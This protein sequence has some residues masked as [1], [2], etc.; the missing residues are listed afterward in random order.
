MRILAPTISC[1]RL[2]RIYPEMLSAG[3]KEAMQVHP[4]RCTFRIEKSYHSA[5]SLHFQMPP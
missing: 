1:S 4:P 2:N 5:S 3:I